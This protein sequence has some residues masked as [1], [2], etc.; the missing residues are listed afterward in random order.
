MGMPPAFLTTLSA[1][2]Q[3][4]GLYTKAT[5]VSLVSCVTDLLKQSA[6]SGLVWGLMPDTFAPLLDE[7]MTET[8]TVTRLSEQDFSSQDFSGHVDSGHAFSAKDLTPANS[9]MGMDPFGVLVVMT[10]QVKGVIYW[11]PTPAVA[12]ELVEGGWSIYPTVVQHAAKAVLQHLGNTNKRLAK[13]LTPQLATQLKLSFVEGVDADA[14]AVDNRLSL[15][16]SAFVK[17]LEQRNQALQAALKESN[18]LHARMVHA[19]RLAAIGQMSA[20]VAHEIRNP[21]GLIELYAK[22][23]ESQVAQL[24]CPAD[25]KALIL[26][27]LGHIMGATQHLG[28]FLH[29]ITDFSKPFQLNCEHASL[30]NLV[31]Q[32]VA[33]SQPLADKL[34]VRLKLMP[35]PLPLRQVVVVVD[36]PRIQQALLN[37]IKNALEVSPP[38]TEVTVRLA[39]YPDQA[40]PASSGVRTTALPVEPCLQVIITDHGKGLPKNRHKQLFTPFFTT[41]PEGTGLGLVRSQAILQAHGGQVTMLRSG[42]KGSAF[43]MALPLFRVKTPLSVAAVT[44]NVL[45]T[46]TTSDKNTS[47]NADGGQS[48]VANQ[49]KGV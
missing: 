1:D 49:V 9:A 11:Q 44:N 6:A 34:Q 16:L 43:A 47:N 22:L 21:L 28:S 33:F 25:T 24:P 26:Q 19:E 41:K 17:G 7:V 45:L 2:C 48:G 32:V 29:E 37:L 20:T 30:Y 36:E 40:K 39:V 38:K 23:A 35:A 3:S 8:L 12:L 31:D 15:F 5:F 27:P 18:T 14:P 13:K 10:D 46:D 4:H 42:P